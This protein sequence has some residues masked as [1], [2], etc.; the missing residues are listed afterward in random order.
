MR[1]SDWSSDVCSSDLAAGHVQI[2][3]LTGQSQP[4]S[5]LQHR[6]YH[7]KAAGIP[8]HHGTPRG[9][10]RGGGNQ[11]L[12]FNQ[13]GAGALEPGEDGGAGDVAAALGKEEGG[14]VGD[15][16]Q[17]LVGHLDAADLVGRRSEERR[18]GTECGSTWR[19]RGLPY[20]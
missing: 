19:S 12:N 3:L 2:Y 17:P 1:I 8:A 14:G 18:V 13:E 5:C 15:L 6:Q 11:G 9:G 10:L 20:Q 7:G 16:L 4:A